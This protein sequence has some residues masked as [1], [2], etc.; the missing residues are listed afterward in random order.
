VIQ[1]VVIQQAAV[2]VAAYLLGCCNTGYY[3][4]RLCTG[5]DI[6]SLASGGTGSRNVGRALGTRGFLCTFIGDA[7]KGALA[8]WLARQTGS[9]EWLAMAALLAAVAGHIW[10]VQLGFRGG[11]GFA[12]LAGGLAVLAPALLLAGFGLSL[13]FLALLRRSTKS[14]LLALCCTPAITAFWRLRDGTALL[15]ADFILY[16]LLV[17]LVLFGH[18]DNIRRDFFGWQPAA[19]LE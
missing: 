3:L 10:P 7:G 18:R 1:Q 6:R 15:S 4:V 13:L 16:L 5:K 17:L 14:G 11:K 2:I 9:G 12:T 8:I 19:A